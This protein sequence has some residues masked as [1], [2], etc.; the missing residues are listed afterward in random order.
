MYAQKGVL[1]V[2]LES[3]LLTLHRASFAKYMLLGIVKEVIYFLQAFR[4]DPHSWLKDHKGVPRVGLEALLLTLE[5]LLLN[6][7]Y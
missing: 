4:S 2:G 3:L 1:R 7:C 5:Q 6:T